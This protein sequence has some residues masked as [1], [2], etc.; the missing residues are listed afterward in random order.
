MPIDNFPGQP[1]KTQQQPYPVTAQPVDALIIGAGGGV[2]KVTDGNLDV[3][4][5][6]GA[7]QAS[8]NY[9]LIQQQE[10]LT[11]ILSELRVI[12]LYM[13][14]QSGVIEEPATLRNDP[15]LLTQ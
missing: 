1:S 6:A 15:T 4:Q 9:M 2:A 11:L 13:Q 3:T 10:L 12:S 5:S 8:L 7:G 14:A